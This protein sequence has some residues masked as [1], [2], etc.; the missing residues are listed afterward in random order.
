MNIGV[1]VGSFNPVHRGHIKIANHLLEKC[2]EKVI[3]VPT[4]GYWDKT[5]LISIQ[6]RINMLNLYKSDK[7]IIEEENNELPYTYWVMKYLQKKYQY[8]NLHLII[9]AD[10]IIAFDKWKNYQELLKYNMIIIE[11]DDVDVKY[12]LDKF[13]KKDKFLIEHVKD[14][15]ISSTMV[16]DLIKESQFGQVTNLIDEQILSYINDNNLYR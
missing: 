10:N 2:L 4:G 14:I 6:H 16:R 3:L 15:D 9:G 7:I 8:D 11:R 5:N 1:Y 12:F 13:E